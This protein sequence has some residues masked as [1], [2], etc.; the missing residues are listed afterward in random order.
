MALLSIA[1]VVELIAKTLYATF[2]AFDDMRPVATC[3]ALQRVSTAA[4]GIPVLLLGGGLLPVSIV[5]LACALLT[6]GYAAG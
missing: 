1:A 3:L 5:Y 4:I 2:Q 6:L